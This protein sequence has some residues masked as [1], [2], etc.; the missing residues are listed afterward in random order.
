MVLLSSIEIIPKV[1]HC[2]SCLTQHAQP[3]GKKCLLNAGESFS[4][5]SE[6][7]APS[8]HNEIMGSDEILQQMRQLGKTNGLYGQEGA[9]YGGST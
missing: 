1:F 7:I 2:T 5:D 9:T 8:S 4:S 3:V 6:V